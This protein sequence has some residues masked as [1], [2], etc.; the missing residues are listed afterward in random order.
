MIRSGK[1]T[2]PS[3]GTSGRSALSEVFP[4]LPGCLE[5]DP[6][7][8]GLTPLLHSYVWVSGPPIF[9]AR[10]TSDEAVAKLRAPPPPRFPLPP[11]GSIQ[12]AR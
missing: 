2:L 8:R 6:A 1:R 7:E 9:G 10:L 11:W 4:V 3:F 5:E 12:V